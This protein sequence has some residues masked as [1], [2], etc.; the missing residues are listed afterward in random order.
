MFV[1]W[2]GQKLSVNWTRPEHFHETDM[3]RAVSIDGQTGPTRI[4]R[5][6]HSP[7]KWYSR[8]NYSGFCAKNTPLVFKSIKS[9]CMWL[10]VWLLAETGLTF[11][12]MQMRLAIQMLLHTL[13]LAISHCHFG[14]CESPTKLWEQL[15]GYRHNP[16]ISWLFGTQ[17]SWWLNNAS[18]TE[19]PCQQVGSRRNQN[20]SR[21][22]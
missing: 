14:V 6:G 16:R 15:D 2:N 17:D 9:T 12:I 3:V 22:I 13:S 5:K 1:I 10:D 20:G 4:M 7:T 11:P 8:N 19:D 21:N 18:L